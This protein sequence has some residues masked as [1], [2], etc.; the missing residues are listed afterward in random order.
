MFGRL[1][2]RRI[3]QALSGIDASATSCDAGDV[4]TRGETTGPGVRST[5]GG[6]MP[7]ALLVALV[8]FTVGRQPPMV[9]PPRTNPRPDIAGRRVRVATPR[10]RPIV[11]TTLPYRADTLVLRRGAEGDSMH[12]PLAAVHKLEVSL[13]RSALGRRRP[14]ALGPRRRRPGRRRSGGCRLHRAWGCCAPD[15]GGVA[16]GLL[17]SGGAGLLVDAIV[18]GHTTERWQQVALPRRTR[19]RIRAAPRQVGVRPDDDA[20]AVTRARRARVRDAGALW[21]RHCREIWR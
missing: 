15:Y 16:S 8:G 17:L 7:R 19:V 21:A 3:L 6:A 1:H 12:I 13:G 18:G 11:G 20:P 4:A 14:A 10:H 2:G 9:Q 5:P